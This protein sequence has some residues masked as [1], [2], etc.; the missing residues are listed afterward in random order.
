MEA[1]G[2]DETQASAVIDMQVRRM[3]VEELSELERELAEIR[4]QLLELEAGHLSA[5]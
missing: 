1:F 4:A 3:T 2:F 5:E